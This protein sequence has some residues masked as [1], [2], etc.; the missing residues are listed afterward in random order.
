[1][2]ITVYLD[3]IF[4]INFIADF[5]VLLLT[6]LI[7]KQRIVLWRLIIGA[8][9]G[10]GMLLFF[11]LSPLLLSGT[12][13]IAFC[14]GISMGAVAI[15]FGRKN[16]GLIRKWFLS[17]TIMI[18]IGSVMNYLKYISGETV[19]QICKWLLCFIASGAC[20][21]FL[22][23]YFRQVMQKEKDIYLIEIKHGEHITVNQVYM[24]TGNFL[25]DPLFEK[26]VILLSESL[27]KS[28]LTEE[29]I[30]IIEQYKKNGRLDY[31]DV[32]TNK[33][34]KRVCFHEIAYKSVGNSSGRLL[35]LLMEKI[36]ILD[37]G[38]ILTKQP[39]AIGPESLFEGKSYQGLLHRKCI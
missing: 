21:Y 24:D 4:I 27:V 5:F 3:I 38:R 29:E 30:N 1:M 28:C 31:K 39:V 32:L 14:I 10:A 23:L 8:V 15:S 33:M 19:F 2:Q 17:T 7:L 25:W 9:F 36:N 35:C 26:P 18:L 11:V 37:A 12:A 6:G 16:G 20:I 34:Q 13:G 22:L